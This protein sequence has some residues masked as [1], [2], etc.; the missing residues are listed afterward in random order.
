MPR[1]RKFIASLMTLAALAATAPL[2]LLADDAP[3]TAPTTA[4]TKM[5][6]SAPA[7]T[8]P[9]PA[10][11]EVP[12]PPVVVPTIPAAPAS[13]TQQFY[14]RVTPGLVAVKFTYDGETVQRDLIVPA[15]VVRSD[16]LVMIPLSAVGEQIPDE[17][18]KNFKIIIPR[19]DVD[20]EE[21]EAEFQGRD[22]RC[23]MAFVK[24]KP[25]TDPKTV[26]KWTPIEFINTPLQVGDQVTS[27]GML[28]KSG[29]YHTIYTSDVVS[30]L[31]RGPIKQVRV[32]SGGLASPHAPVFNT[33]GKAVGITLQEAPAE[34]SLDDD[35]KGQQNQLQALLRLMSSLSTN[36]Y[37]MPTSEFMVGLTDPP[38]PK[39]P[40]PLVWTG[41]TS[42]SGLTKNDAALFNLV[43]Q[44]AI[45]IN[46]I[47]P[48]SPAEKAGL[49]KRD[50]IVKLDGQPLERGDQPDELPSILYHHIL[51]HKP[52]DVLTFTVITGK[53]NAP[54]D[55]PVKL[56]PQPKREIY[57]QRYWSEDIGF[58]VREM[59]KT[60][61]YVLKLKKAEKDGVLVTLLKENGAAA[62]A[63]LHPADMIT[64]VNGQPVTSLD[65]FKKTYEDFRRDHEH[66]A[67]VLVVRRG[68]GEETIR[69]EAPQ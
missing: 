7:A 27:V 18:L 20:S 48:D 15:I 69:I 23:E 64:Q 44:P 61:R 12:V 16:G 56:E 55:V 54:H 52:G 63:G 62:S 33:D 29:G 2:M 32:A 36:R 31:L 41:L 8:Q 57:A 34:L 58:G 6:A 40:V 50:V 17:Q 26:R 35:I 51:Q 13:P 53:G 14:D 4:P 65:S 38:T 49:K 11:V 5:S 47:M 45:Q 37:F 42:Q 30:A 28:P 66:D 67:I 24:A 59:V 46:D 10:V 1:P 9:A 25:A 39:H 68:G 21:V 22:E 43:N 3:T 60:D 19:Q